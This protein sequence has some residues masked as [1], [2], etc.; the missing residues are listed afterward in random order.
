MPLF[1]FA[2]LG[3]ISY[4]SSSRLKCEICE[5]ETLKN[6][7]EKTTT[8]CLRLEEMCN[9]KNEIIVKLEKDLSVFRSYLLV[10]NQPKV[11]DLQ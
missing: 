2:F 9:L 11:N 10:S 3:M 6:S 7:L 4:N 8:E 5:S 1:R